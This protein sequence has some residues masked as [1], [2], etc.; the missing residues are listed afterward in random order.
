MAGAEE[1]AAAGG[2][3]LRAGHAEREQV[4][5]ALKD[6]FVDGRLDQGELD[7][8]AGRALT[9]RT[10]AELAALT[11]DIP[12]DLAAAGPPRPQAV[13]RPPAPARPQAAARPSLVQRR[14]VLW[15]VAG[16]G[17]CLAISFGLI[18]F[19]ANVLDPNGLGNPYHPWSGLCALVAFVVLFTGLGIAI[20][21]LG[22][23]VDH[24]RTRRQLPPTGE[25]P[26]VTAT[27]APPA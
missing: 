11:A 17:S 10:R 25:A 19:A 27:E 9:A 14:P 5:R 8:R 16:S 13:G 15:A 6:A 2:E 18:M 21:G 1:R 3:P 23:A 22:T 20:H 4:V 26:A 12:T 24:R 7:A